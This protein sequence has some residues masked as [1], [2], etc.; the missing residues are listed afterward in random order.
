M[1]RVLVVGWLLACSLSVA[2]G[3]PITPARLAQRMQAA[4]EPAPLL[5]D[6]RTPQEFA[7]GHIPGA[8]LVPHDQLD[9]RLGELERGRDVVVYCKTGRRAALAESLLRA[10]GF[11]VRQL[12][13]SWVAWQAAGLPVECDGARC[14][15][16]ETP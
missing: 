14:A 5:L 16:T 1:L 11:Q 6:V 13:G 7:A 8:R 15:S 10:E 4:N 3:G 12:Q 2:A 9:A